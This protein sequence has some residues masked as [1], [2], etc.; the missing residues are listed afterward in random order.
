MN[1]TAISKLLSLVLRHHPQK[2][3]IQLDEQGWTDTALLISKCNEYG[4]PLDAM[5]LE[6]LV[7]QNDKKRFAFNEDHTRIRASQGHSVTVNLALEPME[8]PAFLYHGTVQ[9]FIASIREKGLQKMQRTHVHLSH[10]AETA[11]KV[12]SRRGKPLILKIAAVNMHRDGFRFFISQNGVW[13]TDEV[14]PQYILF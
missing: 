7:Q 10:D 9:K 1:Q 12:G 2:I 13:L 8:P 5:Q 14:P 3:G 4:I 11:F 6:A